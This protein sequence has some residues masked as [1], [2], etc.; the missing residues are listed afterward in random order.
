MGA[1]Q[2]E[3]ER[4]YDDKRDKPANPKQAF[5]DKK[6]RLT[7]LP[8]TA[9][10]AQEEA[11]RDGALKYG[12]QNWR[13]QPVEIM[14][15][16]DAA[17]RHLRLFENGER[18]AR[19][20]KVDNLGAVMACCAIIIDAMAHESVI[21]NRRPSTAACDALH[22]RGEKMVAHLREM[23]S[24]RE[25][26]KKTD[27]REDR[28]RPV[29]ARGASFNLHGYNRLELKFKNYP[30]SIF[31]YP[32]EWCARNLQWAEVQAWRPEPRG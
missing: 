17:M 28:W 3:L 31:T 5:G 7:L 21:D 26:A 18:Y 29:P 14:T 16:V 4:E 13:D 24:Q 32:A 1:I 10:L 2:D 8:M 27:G 23:Q 30:D 15:Y 22:D 20:T 6:P 11:H 25:A 19:D 9:M 12:E